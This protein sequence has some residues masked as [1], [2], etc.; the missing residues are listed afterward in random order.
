[1]KYI[2]LFILIQLVSLVLTIVGIPVCAV[3]AWG[4]FYHY[5]QKYHWPKWAWVWDNEEDGVA[6][7]GYTTRWGQ[8]VWTALR[9]PCN[10]LRFVVGVSGSGRPLLYKTWTM[11]GKEFYLKWGWMSDGYPAFS[12]GAGRGY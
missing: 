7:S 9:N 12:A 4:R 8:F 11:F 2:A 3:L 6:P 10:N 1:M 5:D